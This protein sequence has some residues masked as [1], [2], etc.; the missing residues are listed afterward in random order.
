MIE[1]LI[2]NVEIYEGD[3]DTTRG[4]IREFI[5]RDSEIKPNI[6]FPGIYFDNYGLYEEVLR[7]TQ[8][9]TLG[10][11]IWTTYVYMDKI[12]G[13]IKSDSKLRRNRM[14][15]RGKKTETGMIG[16]ISINDI[17]RKDVAVCSERATFLHNILVLSGVSSNLIFGSLNCEA[18]AYILLQTKCSKALL[19]VSNFVCYMQNGQMFREPI[20]VFISEEEYERIISGGEYKLNINKLFSKNK[21]VNN[22][23]LIY[24]GNSFC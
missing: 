6:F 24:Q 17:L 9:K 5:G 21:P 7:V 10:Y 15:A 13:K 12:F 18:H 20:L 14:F 2:R 11:T 4:I 1:E 22:L 3:V 19:D 16:A 8:S 23:N